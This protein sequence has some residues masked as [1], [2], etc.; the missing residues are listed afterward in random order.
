[1]RRAMH[2]GR[3]SGFILGYTY[4]DGRT[5]KLLSLF[6]VAHLVM[7]QGEVVQAFP[8]SC[9]LRTVDIWIGVCEDGQR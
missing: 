9:W 7:P 5:I 4:M 3:R 8:T 2:D 1:M 6:V